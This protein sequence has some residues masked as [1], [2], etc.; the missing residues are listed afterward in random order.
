VKK[1]FTLLLGVT[2]SYIYR[3]KFNP[4]DVG[5]GGAASAWAGVAIGDFNNDG[6]KDVAAAR[7]FDGSIFL[8]KWDFVLNI[9]RNALSQTQ[10]LTNGSAS[11]W[12]GDAIGDLDGQPGD[13]LAAIR[14]FDNTIYIK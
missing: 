2:Y 7:N 14:N 8:Y 3:N 12:R 1:N 9:I 6:I 11:Q 10:I 13:E 5:E 4:I